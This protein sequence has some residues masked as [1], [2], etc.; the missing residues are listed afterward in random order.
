[1]NRLRQ[2]LAR[3]RLT[4]AG[5]QIEYL[6]RRLWHF[7]ALLLHQQG[8]IASQHEDNKSLK[9]ALVKARFDAEGWR[10]VAHEQARQMQFAQ[11]PAATQE[12]K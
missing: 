6:N 1:M 7:E 5:A 11:K 2:W 3:R 9:A 10:Q 4:P 12:A 8:L